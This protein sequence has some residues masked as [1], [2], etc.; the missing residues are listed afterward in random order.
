MTAF[1]EWTWGKRDWKGKV[2]EGQL[3]SECHLKHRLGVFLVGEEEYLTQSYKHTF[4]RWVGVLGD[5][6]KGRMGEVIGRQA[7]K[8]IANSTPFQSLMCTSSTM[9]L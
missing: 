9:T 5:G 6:E 2:H 4:Q 7:V 8:V 3:T 1:V